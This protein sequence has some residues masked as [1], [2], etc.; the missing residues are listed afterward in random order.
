MNTVIVAEKPSVGRDIARVLG[1]SQPGDGC[2]M[3]KGYIVTWALGHLVSLMEPDELDERYRRWRMD[4]LPILPE[5]IPL[6]VLPATRGQFAIV[7]KLMND[8]DTAEVICAT[9]AA[10]E[11]ELIFRYIYR[12]AG[13]KKPV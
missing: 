5:D 12:M 7:K 3:G 2:L 6:K 1:A 8:K 4:D 13:C 9:D 10:R 11:G